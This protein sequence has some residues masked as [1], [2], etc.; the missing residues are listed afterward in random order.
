[1]T[2]SA[3]K[4][5]GATYR[6]L[7][8]APEHKV[9]EI[10]AGELHLSPRPGGPATSVA[11]N[12][13][14]DLA[15]PFSRGRGGPGDWIILFEPEIHVGDDIVAPDL[16]GWRRDRLQL[17][18]DAAFISVTPDWVCEV[19]SPSTERFDRAFKL[20][21]Y[22]QWGIKHVWL[23]HPRHRT[24]EIYRLHSGGMWTLV[25]VYEDQD[26]VRAEPF[27]SVELDL[28]VW[29]ADMAL[30]ANE[31]AAEYGTSL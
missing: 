5:R 3:G 23:V 16:A 2:E 18:P 25:A 30:H 9:A 6:D 13:F 1:M 19:L 14:S 12:I 26:H 28:G 21:L 4:K 10:I 11:S 31:P 29:W 22:S 15:P 20:P 17:V 7:L 24:L 8:D 27:D